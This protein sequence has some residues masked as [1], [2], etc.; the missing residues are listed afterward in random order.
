MVM[1]TASTMACIAEALGMSLP[2]AATIPAVHAERLR[3][4]EASGTRAAAIAT[5]ALRPD[6][7]LSPPRRS[8]TRWSCCTRSAVR[9]NALIHLT[10]IA[11]RRGI[12]IDLDRFDALGRK[13]PVLVDL[14]PSGQHYMEHLHEAGGL[15][16]VLRELEPFLHLD[17]PTVSGR[18]LGEV[19]AAAEVVADQQVVRTRTNPIFRQRRD[20]R[21]AAAISRRAAR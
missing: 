13:V 14:K 10:A 1:G 17:V 7:I 12:R 5:R 9:R 19:I 4:A 15:N 21:A 16:A 3:L 18:T 2:G 11:A 6:A 20:R 8:P